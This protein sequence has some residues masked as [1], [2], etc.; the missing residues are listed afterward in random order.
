MLSATLTKLVLRFRKVSKDEK[1]INALQ[2]EAML[3]MTSVVRVG[4]SK[5][6]STPIDED[7]MERIIGCLRTLSDANS[8]TPEE[9]ELETI[10]LQ[11]TK[12]AYAKMVATEEVCVMIFFSILVKSH[13]S[14]CS[15]NLLRRRRRRTRSS[16]CKRTMFLHSDNSQRGREWM[17]SMT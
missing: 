11:D 15:V 10:Y 5:F 13:I 6:S 14:A 1:G 3:I 17:G 9:A 2:A 12:A 4:Q 7:S 8:Q 16:P